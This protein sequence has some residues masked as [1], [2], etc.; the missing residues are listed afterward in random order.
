MWLSASRWKTARGELELRA[1]SED[2]RAWSTTAIS[3]SQEQDARRRSMDK[4]E[5][6]PMAIAAP[7]Q[8]F[9]RGDR[10]RDANERGSRHLP[11]RARPRTPAER[12]KADPLTSTAPRPSARIISAAT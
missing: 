12:S 8:I 7:A 11:P 5:L 4:F 10:A 3:I 2:L 9:A 6:T 1:G